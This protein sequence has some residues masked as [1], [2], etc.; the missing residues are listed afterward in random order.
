[1]SFFILM[2]IL[3]TIFCPATSAGLIGEVNSQEENTTSG[4]SILT[5]PNTQ[6]IVGNSTVAFSVVKLSTKY[7]LSE[8]GF[9]RLDL[10]GLLRGDSNFKE[11]YLTSVYPFESNSLEFDY[12]FKKE[13]P[14]SSATSNI[15][16]SST[17]IA[18]ISIPES[19]QS[20]AFISLY[21]DIKCLQTKCDFQVSIED[22][23]SVAI[24]AVIG[25][26]LG[27]IILVIIGI[28]VLVIWLRIYSPK[29]RTDEDKVKL[30]STHV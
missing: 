30:T 21:M 4:I 20:S 17:I 25:S 1:M 28:M 5:L 6:S 14:Y 3:L 10:S 23:V 15:P 8:N 11:I 18:Q 16:A 26:I 19:L 7:T 22:G 29:Y 9:V 12:S 24:G 27:A 13:G 2:T